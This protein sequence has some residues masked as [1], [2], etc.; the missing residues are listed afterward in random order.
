MYIWNLF[1]LDLKKPINHLK[2]YNM[3]KKKSWFDI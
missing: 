1:F 2:L 3:Q